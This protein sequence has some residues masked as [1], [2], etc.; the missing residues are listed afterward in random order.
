M[1]LYDGKTLPQLKRS[2]SAITGLITKTLTITQPIMN[3]DKNEVTN[4]EIADLEVRQS[5]FE[6]KLS[7]GEFLNA[8]ILEQIPD[9]DEEVQDEFITA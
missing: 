6:K 7:E 8:V 4:Q 1:S 2:R 9:T 5:L 3:K